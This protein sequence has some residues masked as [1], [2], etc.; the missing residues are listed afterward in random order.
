MIGNLSEKNNT[1]VIISKGVGTVEGVM[2]GSTIGSIVNSIVRSI[3]RSKR[4][5]GV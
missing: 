5:E 2:I 3:I 4:G 1:S